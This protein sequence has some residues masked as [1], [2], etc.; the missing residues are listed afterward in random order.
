MVDLNTPIQTRGPLGH[1]I[2][3]TVGDILA[4]DKA[5]SR[6]AIGAEATADLGALATLDSV[7]TGQIDNGAVTNAKLASGAA[8]G[9]LLTA[10]LGA[11]KSYLKTQNTADTLLA[12]ATGD[13]SVL[14]VVVVD[15]TFAD[16]GG[17]QPTFTIGQT[18]TANKF[19]G[20][21][22][23][24]NK[25]AGT[26]LTFAGTLTG[27]DNLIVTGVHATVDGTGGITVTVLALPAA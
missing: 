5:A 23:F 25:T 26:V 10:G 7:G 21:A 3:T 22:A 18:G 19:A 14:I 24:A 6:A 20:T 1:P 27:T 9:A 4:A 15:E 13:R 16:V 12:S 17:T 2:E 8:V 11:S